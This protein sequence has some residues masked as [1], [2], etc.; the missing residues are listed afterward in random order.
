[1]GSGG[2]IAFIFRSYDGNQA[3]RDAAAHQGTV[4]AWTIGHFVTAYLKTFGKGKDSLAF[5]ETVYEPIF[6]HLKTAGLGTVSEMFDGNF[7]YNA[8]GRT[9]HAWAVA[10]LLRSYL[11]DY[12][13]LNAK[14]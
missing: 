10:E 7:P 3:T 11:E 12:L 9:S 8:R 5:I 14:D 13:D 2:I 6:E 1:L 4:W